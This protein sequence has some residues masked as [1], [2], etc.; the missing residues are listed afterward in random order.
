MK[1]APPTPKWALRP[2]W[3]FTLSLGTK[4]DPLRQSIEPG[5]PTSKGLFADAQSA[6]PH[7]LAREAYQ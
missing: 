5:R 7:P 6:G 1:R 3:R 2:A 4:D